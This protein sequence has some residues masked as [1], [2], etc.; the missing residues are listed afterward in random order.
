MK[1]NNELKSKGI[2]VPDPFAGFIFNELLELCII[3]GSAI[4]RDEFDPDSYSVPD[5][6]YDQIE[7]LFLELMSEAKIVQS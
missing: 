5:F 4:Y 2:I 3:T 1:V 7:K 6:E